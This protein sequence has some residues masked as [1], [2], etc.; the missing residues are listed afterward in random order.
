[1]SWA[2]MLQ[3]TYDN[4]LHMVG[5]ETDDAM[6]APLAHMNARAQVEVLLNL[7]GRFLRASKINKED[8][9]TMIPVTESS[10]GRASGIAPHPLCDTL[11]YIAGDYSDYVDEKEGE[12]SKNKFDSYIKNLEQWNR[13]TKTH[14]VVKA[15]YNYLNK[16]TLIKDLVQ[17]DIIKLNQDG[18]LSNEKINGVAYEKVI[19]RFQVTGGEV[20]NTYQVGKDASLFQAYVDYYVSNMDG[21]KE[22]CYLSG[23]VQTIATNHPKG[24]VSSD[25]GAKL[26]SAN[27][28][29]GFTYRGRFEKPE[30]ACV[31]GYD[32]TQRVH[33][34]LTWLVKKQGIS[35]GNTE[36]RTYVC[37]NPLG[38][39]VP[40]IELDFD[41]YE[42]EDEDSYTEESYKMKLYQT[43]QGY[44][45]ELIDNDDIIVIGLDAATTGRLSITYYNELKASDFWNR[46]ET[47]YKECSWYFNIFQNDKFKISVQSVIIK[48]IVRCAYGT[49]Q[50][51]FLEVNDKI[52]KEQSQRLIHCMLDRKP[53]SY[54][55]VH[56]VFNK[57]S[58]PT[59]Y[60]RGN[61][62]KILSTACALIKKYN[63]EK[64][65]GGH[66]SMT[67]DYENSDRSYLFGRL[68]AVLERVERSTY[69]RGEKR[70][71]NAIRLWNAYVN[72]PG[73]TWQTLEDLLVPY[74]TKL[75]PG[76]RTYY[77]NIIGEIISK[78]EQ[79]DIH[80]LNRKLDEN[81]LIGYYLQ[82]MELRKYNVEGNGDEDENTG[83]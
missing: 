40:E 77:K 67:I 55:L 43:L 45:N 22:R 49:E 65:K 54:E 14:V 52:M 37:W 10:A 56:A 23:K 19:V 83:E 17:S 16:T 44:K 35:F 51:K 11:S 42:G 74:Y 64:M 47:W 30:E 33:N 79:E 32:T 31:I 15:V 20:S 73:K 82:R 63:Y 41:I 27:D 28:M 68:L 81:Y 25:Y 36:K 7:E 69:D 53:I 58:M 12:K 8:E 24:I 50:G 21:L 57:V 59:A 18:L 71:P 6:L 46:I 76:S 61:W 1:M 48:E 26:I 5:K 2:S 38:K 60:S 75:L 72:H 78:L 9:I 66:V 4:N 39:R 62:E 34:T 3:Q 29:Q 70:E 80:S 13:S